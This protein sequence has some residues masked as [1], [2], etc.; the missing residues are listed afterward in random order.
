[1]TGKKGL[2]LYNSSSPSFLVF[3]NDTKRRTDTEGLLAKCFSSDVSFH[4]HFHST[5][6]EMFYLELLDLDNSHYYG[7]K[8]IDN[9]YNTI[10]V[11]VCKPGAHSLQNTRIFSLS[12]KLSSFGTEAVLELKS[13]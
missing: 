10:S 5:Y 6:S 13:T 1:M 8:T 7:L 4:F 11:S 2:C 3:D 12:G 9:N